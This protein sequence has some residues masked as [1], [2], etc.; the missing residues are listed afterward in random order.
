MVTL[1]KA[2]PHK[3]CLRPA[4]IWMWAQADSGSGCPG[5]PSRAQG[6]L[7]LLTGQPVA[8]PAEGRGEGTGESQVHVRRCRQFDTGSATQFPSLL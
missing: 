4:S 1:V 2:V 7:E 8:S 6:R 5:A 3:A